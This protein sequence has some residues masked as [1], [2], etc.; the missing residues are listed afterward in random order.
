MELPSNPEAIS[1]GHEG[2]F[3]EETPGNGKARNER[4]RVFDPAILCDD[5]FVLH[6]HD[7]AATRFHSYTYIYTHIHTH[8]YINT[9]TLEIQWNVLVVPA[10]TPLPSTFSTHPSK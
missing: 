9:Y 7:S 6:T 4:I 1:R 10:T 5:E 3:R 8:T 2:R